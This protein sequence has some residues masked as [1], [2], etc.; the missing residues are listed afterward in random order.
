MNIT[1][2]LLFIAS[3]LLACL[4]AII[5][6]AR[7]LF[8][9]L[10]ARGIWQGK[11][12]SHRESIRTSV[13]SLV[14]WGISCAALIAFWQ[15]NE[16]D[17]PSVSER[18]GK[19]LFEDFE[20]IDVK[21][22]EIVKYD[23]STNEFDEFRIEQR[24]SDL[25]R[26]P[27]HNNYPADALEQVQSAANSLINLEVKGVIP[28]EQVDHEVFGVIEPDRQK[29]EA[30]TEGVGTKVVLRDK[31][32]RDL[33]N[34]IIGKPVKGKPQ[35]RFV[36]IP[37]QV[38]VYVVEYD[39]TVLKTDFREWIE[40]DLLQLEEIDIAQVRL[41]DYQVDPDLYMQEGKIELTR[42]YELTAS[43]NFSDW[44]PVKLIYYRSE[45]T[46]EEETLGE[47][48]E[49]NGLLLDELRA[50]LDDLKIVE[51]E[52][53]PEGLGADL[54]AGLDFLSSASKSQERYSLAS[55][56][57]IPQKVGDKVEILSSNGELIVQTKDGIE[58][59]LRFGRIVTGTRAE[60]ASGD[61]NR[62]LMVTTRVNED[63]FPMPIR[64]QA[65][66]SGDVPPPP[67]GS[68][69]PPGGDDTAAQETDDVQQRQQEREFQRQVDER[70]ERIKLA[71]LRVRELN[72]RFADWYYVISEEAYGKLR[73]P[74]N[75]LVV[76]KP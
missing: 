17:G 35:Q 6:V 36:R 11:W 9:F 72:D 45:Q 56:G 48:Q 13:F 14:G 19:P 43:V 33:A 2:T 1:W 39:T 7:L 52:Q 41:R 76:Q 70:N 46:P 73:I 47:N 8:L 22:L 40:R 32:N 24:G 18:Q 74:T 67:G 12:K 44:E 54:T 61:L 53:K 15:A 5:E 42:N 50:S 31:N 25:W 10:A 68:V 60:A 63:F 75:K 55:H 51:V 16:V 38:P 28:E 4:G 71:K 26:I 21:R 27:S 49:L 57:F 20:P 59:V 66:T 37:G 65:S 29:I 23:S 69:P 58:Y 3:I 30:G 64:Q 34:L 62:Y